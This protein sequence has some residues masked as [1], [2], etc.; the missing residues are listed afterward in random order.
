[1]VPSL[2]VRHERIPEGMVTEGLRRVVIGI[3]HPQPTLRWKACADTTDKPHRE[4]PRNVMLEDF[5]VPRC[6]YEDT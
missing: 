3:V 6:G 1:M 4:G 2:F 5:I